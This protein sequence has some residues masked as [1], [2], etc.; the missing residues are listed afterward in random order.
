MNSMNPKVDG[1]LRNAKKRQQE[2]KKLRMIILNRQPPEELKRR[3]PCY[4][5]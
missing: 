4:M 3:A 1:Y 2:L 5:F